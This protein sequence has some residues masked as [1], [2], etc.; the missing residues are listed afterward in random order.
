MHLWPLRAFFV[1]LGIFSNFLEKTSGTKLKLPTGTY[2]ASLDK[3]PISKWLLPHSKQINR[4]E[5]EEVGQ[6]SSLLACMQVSDYKSAF[7]PMYL[8]FLEL[9]THHCHTDLKLFDEGNNINI[10]RL[11][12]L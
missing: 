12:Y 10:P 4:V 9:D 3:S 6:P 5:N 7:I 1:A 2:G 11:F 8:V